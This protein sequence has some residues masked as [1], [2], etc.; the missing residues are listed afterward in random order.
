MGRDHRDERDEEDEEEVRARILELAARSPFY[1]WTGMRVLRVEP[2]EVDVA[3]DVG[4]D[5][6]NLRGLLHG[7]MIATLADSASGLA[8]RSALEPGRTHATVQ[9]DVRFL[10]A[11]GPGTIEARGRA[12]R[13][14]RSIAFAEA[15]IVDGDGTTLARASATHAVSRAEPGVDQ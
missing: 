3:M 4:P 10:R 5:H 6:L 9:L 12:I 1:A 14:G 11:G 2:G 8:V 13:V 7:G 15:E